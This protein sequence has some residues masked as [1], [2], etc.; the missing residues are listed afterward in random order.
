MS[1][2]IKCNESAEEIKRLNPE[3]PLSDWKNWRPGLM[4]SFCT[5]CVFMYIIIYIYTHTHTVR[6]HL[7]LR[8]TQTPTSVPSPLI[9]KVI[10]WPLLIVL[11]LHI[12]FCTSYF[13]LARQWS[14][15][16]FVAL[17]SHPP[18]PRPILY[19]R[20]GPSLPCLRNCALLSQ[21]ALSSCWESTN[22]ATV[23]S[24]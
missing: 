8:V 24:V 16:A 7:S 1:K 4:S 19:H 5:Q 6:M 21:W 20:P 18:A 2:G 11:T 9:Q 12:P 23:S 10:I 13:Q 3:D 14:P 17:L 15:S 22:E